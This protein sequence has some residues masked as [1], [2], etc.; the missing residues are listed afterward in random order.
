MLD[1]SILNEAQK[2]AVTAP[3]GPML[4]IA[5]AGSGKTRTI[6]YRL[7]WLAEH[8]TDPHAM[9]LLTFTRKAS[10]EMLHRAANLL[11][12]QLLKEAYSERNTGVCR[13]CFLNSHLKVIF[14]QKLYNRVKFVPCLGR[15]KSELIEDI[16]TVKE[17]IE[18]L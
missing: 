6:V 14:L 7:A 12:Q 15:F 16:L 10:Q 4:V 3:E 9:L 5:G 18:V 11:E 2:E 13:V 17:H 1:L 8:G